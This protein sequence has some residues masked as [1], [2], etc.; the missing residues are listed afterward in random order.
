[1]HLLDGVCKAG[2]HK[3]VAKIGFFAPV[4]VG[5]PLSDNGVRVALQLQVRITCAVDISRDISTNS[6]VLGA[7]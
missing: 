1:M 5:V 7:K 2:V 6:E 3:G 4:K